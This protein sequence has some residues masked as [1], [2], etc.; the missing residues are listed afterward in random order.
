MIING[1]CIV[2]LR[3]LIDSGVKVDLI[4]T[5]PPYRVISGGNKTPKWISG[6]GSSCLHRNDGKIFDHNDVNAKDWMSLCYDILKEGS[7][8]YVMANTLNLFS[9]KE[10]AESCGFSLHNV[11]VWEKNN[12]NASRWYMKNCEYTLFFRKGKAKKINNP[13]SKTVH[14]FKNPVGNKVHPTEKPV[15]LMEFYVSNSSNVG[16]IVLDPFMGAGSTGV[17]CKNLNRKFIGIELDKKYY[18][19][20]KQ[21]LE[22][23]VK[24]KVKLSR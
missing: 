10:I 7:H 6:Y 21:R 9:F 17:A 8:F 4:V 13:S 24:L 1:D 18:D 2:E 12:A 16:D 3:K 20:A 22:P 15:D 5:D 11:L 14:K 23:T 19:I